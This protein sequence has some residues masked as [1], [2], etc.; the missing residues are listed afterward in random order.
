MT[1]PFDD[2]PQMQA[3]LAIKPLN[4]SIY[5]SAASF[6]NY[7]SGIYNDPTCGNQ[8]NH[9]TNVVGIGELNGIQYWVM[10]NSWGTDWGDMGYMKM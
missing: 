4:V 8:H 2:I 3:A 10:R 1:V 5:A 7:Q 6:R 9:A